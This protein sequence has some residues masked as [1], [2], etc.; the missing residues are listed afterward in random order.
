MIL[1][2][3]GAV[4][5]LAEAIPVPQQEDEPQSDPLSPRCLGQTRPVKPPLIM[6]EIIIAVQHQVLT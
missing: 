6:S 5:A 1:S 4:P 2:A 3:C